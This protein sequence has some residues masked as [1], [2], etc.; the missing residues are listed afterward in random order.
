MKKFI[1][2]KTE[3]WGK[4]IYGDIKATLIGGRH[5]GMKRYTSD[6]TLIEPDCS[7][8]EYEKITH[9]TYLDNP[10]ALYTSNGKLLNDGSEEFIYIKTSSLKDILF[11]D[12][13]WDG[14]FQL[15]R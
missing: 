2:T 11:N 5:D 13:D 3:V 8:E 6:R 1:P 15:K 14:T 7:D 10:T 9:K 12:F 4:P